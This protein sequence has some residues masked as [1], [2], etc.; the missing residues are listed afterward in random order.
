MTHGA[1]ALAMSVAAQ[2]QMHAVRLEEEVVVPMSLR[3]TIVDLKESMCK[4]PL[5]DPTTSEFRY[6][7]SPVPNAP[8]LIASITASSPIS[9]RR[10][11]A[12]IATAAR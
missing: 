5:G 12:A 8:G 6:C 9:R 1:N 2:P 10:T 3:V 7:G 11:A 4:W